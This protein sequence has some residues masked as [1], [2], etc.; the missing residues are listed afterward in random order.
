MKT[1]HI[2]ACD[3]DTFF[4]LFAVTPVLCY[5]YAIATPSPEPVRSKE[6]DDT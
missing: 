2:S 4:P 5:G 3:R 6:S 1:Q